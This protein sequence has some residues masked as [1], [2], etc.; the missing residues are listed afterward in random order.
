MK[1]HGS[2]L[3]LSLVLLVLI[4]GAPATQESP[5]LNEKNRK[6][7]RIFKKWDRASSPGCA[8]GVVKDGKLIRAVGYGSMNLEYGLPITSSTVF[9]VASVSKQFTCFAVALLAAEGKLSLD[10]DI[11]KYVPEVPD[12]GRCITIRHLIHHTSGFRDQWDLLVLAGWRM[13][14][15]ITLEDVMALVRRQKELNFDP[16]TRFL[17]C[18]TGYTPLAVVVERV[19]GKSLR[20]FARKKMFK[21]LGMKNTHF[22]DDHQHIVKNRAYCYARGRWMGFKK[23]VL[24][25]AIVGATSLFTTVEDLARW[26]ENFTTARVGGRKVVEMMLTRGTLNNGR[27]LNYSSGLLHGEYR[28]FKTIE[29]SGGDAGFRCH[30]VRFPGQRLSIIVL[31]N[32]ASLRTKALALNVAGLYLEGS[33]PGPGVNETRPVVDQAVKRRFALAGEDPGVTREQLVGLAGVWRDPSTT[34]TC[35][36]RPAKGGLDLLLGRRK[37]NLVPVTRSRFAAKPGHGLIG[38]EI[39]GKE[40][41]VSCLT[42]FFTSGIRR[43]FRATEPITADVA[44]LDRIV[45]RYYSEELDRTLDIE[46]RKN[47][48]FILSLKTGARRM[49]PLYRDGYRVKQARFHIMQDAGGL[50]EGFLVSTGRVLNLRFKKVRQQD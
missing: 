15:V 5:P 30:M 19:S 50:V 18:N 14:D 4:T 39:T 17:Y 47:N 32:L 49:G 22:H 31:G 34:E 1:N 44:Y 20:V 36:L 26:Q 33:T 11:R 48:L 28:G 9:H 27:K 3:V 6:I 2:G 42:A 29:H 38:V 8:L 45:G 25:Y 43:T 13:E 40:N 23:I 21:P 24:S 12:F 16:G 10:D 35:R 41:S 37:V 7:D 46:R